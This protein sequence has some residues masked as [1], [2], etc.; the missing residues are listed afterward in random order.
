MDAGYWEFIPVGAV[1]MLYKR[2]LVE[3]KRRL[4]VFATSPKRSVTGFR[5]EEVSG[6]IRSTPPYFLSYFETGAGVSGLR[7]S[8]SRSGV[9]S[10]RTRVG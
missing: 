9:P 6:S 4:I 7:I 5:N 1:A 8:S 3:K 2:K 10:T